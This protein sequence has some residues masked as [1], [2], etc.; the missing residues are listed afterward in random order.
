MSTLEERASREFAKVYRG[1]VAIPLP[2]PIKRPVH[3]SGPV[4]RIKPT[5][6]GP[7][8]DL[9]DIEVGQSLERK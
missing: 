4:Q 5:R 7:L 3:R 1:Q 8:P 6:V 9:S 2:A